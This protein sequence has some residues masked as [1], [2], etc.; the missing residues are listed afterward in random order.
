MRKNLLL[1]VLA[2]IF[3]SATIS[4]AYDTYN[5]HPLI[6]ENALL[7]SNVDGYLKNQL[8]FTKGITERFQ[9]K[10]VTEWIKEGAKLEDETVCRSRNHFHDPLKPW[11]SAGLNNAAVN[12]YCLLLG[13][14]KFSVDSSLIWAQKESL[15][16]FYDNLWSWQKARKY[17]Y[18]ALTGK[19]FDSNII[20]PTK[21]DREKYFAYTFRALGQVMHLIADSSVPAHVRNDIHV[22]PLDV[23]GIGEVGRP[24]YESWAKK[25]YPWFNYSGI[26]VDQSIFS[27][28][29]SDSS[30]PVTITA[31]WD[32]NKYTGIN[33]SVTWTTNPSISSY[34]LTEFT[35]A[36]FF[37]EDTIF[38]SYTHPAKENT[39]A[40]LVE[41]YA[42]DGKTD[43]VWYIQGYTS[44][45]LAAYSYLNK[46]L[47]P[48]KWEYNLDGFVYGD[49][50]SQLIP[51]AVGYSAGLLD[52]FFR[53]EMDM[54]PE[55]SGYV[56]VNNTDEDMGGTFELW[57]DNKNDERVKVSG[58]SWTLSINKKSSSNNKSTNI[59]F[60]AP[61]DAKEPG[62]YMLVFRGKL[63]N[64]EEAV[65]G[66]EIMLIPPLI[67][68]HNGQN[69]L[70]MSFDKDL[71]L[72]PYPPF[73]LT[74]GNAGLSGIETTPAT[75]QSNE[76][77]TEHYYM[78]STTQN[79][80]IRSSY[81]KN[82]GRLNYGNHLLGNRN[83]FTPTGWDKNSPLEYN[84]TLRLSYTSGRHDWAYRGDNVIKN[85]EALENPFRVRYSTKDGVIIGNALPFSSVYAVL[86]PTKVIG[87]SSDSYFYNTYEEGSV[88][89]TG[90][91]TYPEF[92]PPIVDYRESTAQYETYR[93]LMEGNKFYFGDVILGTTGYSITAIGSL[94][95]ITT[96]YFSD[97]DSSDAQWD[98]YGHYDAAHYSFKGE[99][100]WNATYEIKDYDD[101]DEDKTFIVMYVKKASSRRANGI[102]GGGFGA[103]VSAAYLQFSAIDPGYYSPPL[104]YEKFNGSAHI[105]QIAYRLRGGE[106][107]Q[108]DVCRTELGHYSLLD[109]PGSACDSPVYASVDIT[110][111]FRG[112][113]MFNPSTKIFGYNGKTYIVYSYSIYDYIGDPK[114][115]NFDS[116]LL[117]D[118]RFNKR[119]VGLIDA[120]TGQKSET[121]ITDAFLGDKYENFDK[122][123]YS[124]IGFH[125]GRGK[126]K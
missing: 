87:I 45:R 116:E 107:H 62:K 58:A 86:S 105:Y 81:F 77:F 21:T 19:N 61:T 90:E 24:T 7:Q 102:S 119:I 50:A 64:E 38:K 114:V 110:E 49:Y 66:K 27:Q 43:K 89:L 122:T 48:D 85:F 2:I 25:N 65:V 108:E 80:K 16:P 104:H 23:L 32:Q 33:P 5:V 17:Y 76:T 29:V 46:W 126:E 36:N 74:F 37:S 22:F 82:Y 35:N 69:T 40:K 47:L 79:K 26:T 59:T 67:F 70:F 120:D 1:T 75:I 93:L 39:T 12:T 30:A 98:S 20:A 18:I 60:D 71:K 115:A 92:V 57:Y 101:I 31:L 118:W 73:M 34:G 10:E 109:L 11:D 72:T 55:G 42:K 117:S 78:P 6:N 123:L 9:Q 4:N 95:G 14:E 53:G 113:A 99:S 13:Y 41:Q 63:G 83:S 112:Q 52:Y 97:I 8:G 88:I 91:I 125:N 100:T 28:A 84:S 56:I 54:V 15:N 106:L 51:R 124:A 3:S 94:A 68:L 44:Q 96:C 121:E 103:P 111:E